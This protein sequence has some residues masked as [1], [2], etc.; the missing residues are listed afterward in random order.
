MLHYDCLGTVCASGFVR[1]S[2]Y[3]AILVGMIARTKGAS[4]G[5]CPAFL[6]GVAKALAIV[7]S[8][9]FR[10]ILLEFIFNKPNVDVCWKVFFKPKNNC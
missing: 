9:R 10:D 7:T 2:F 5:L 4:G 8:C 6:N 3:G 1:V